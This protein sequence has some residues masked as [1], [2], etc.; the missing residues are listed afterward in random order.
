VSWLSVIGLALKLLSLAVT[1]LREKQLLKAGEALAIAAA[2]RE[3][4]ARVETA[5]AARRAAAAAG[6]M[7]DDDPYL[8]D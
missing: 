8:R 1:K 7:Q 4:H 3:T 5:L 6:G 2:L